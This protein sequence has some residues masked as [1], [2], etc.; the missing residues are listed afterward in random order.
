MEGFEVLGDCFLKLIVSMSLYHRHPTEGAGVLTVV[1]TRQISNKN[2]YR[3]AMMKKLTCYLNAKKLEFRGKNANWVPPG[4]VVNGSNANQNPNNF[5]FK[6]YEYQT[7]KRKAFADMMES[8][9]G[10]FLLSTDYPTTI[11]F[12]LWLGLDVV[13]LDKNSRN[14]FSKKTRFYFC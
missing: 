10:A 5:E 3:I 2:L 4:Y 14:S 6:R 7:V 12:M 11:Q 13:P 1:K 8:F 9:M